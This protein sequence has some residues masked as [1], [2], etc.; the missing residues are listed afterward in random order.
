MNIIRFLLLAL[1]LT[2]AANAIQIKNKGQLDEIR[3]KAGDI[4]QADPRQ[5]QS[6]HAGRNPPA[7]GSKPPSSSSVQSK[8]SSPSSSSSKGQ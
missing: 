3:G 2:P 4:R 5:V 7:P 1:V 8:S 6:P